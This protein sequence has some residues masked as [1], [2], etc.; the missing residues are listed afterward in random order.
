MEAENVHLDTTIMVDYLLKGKSKRAAVSG[1]LGQ[2][3]NSTTSRY[4]KA[5]FKKGPLQYLVYLHN[6]FC[7]AE[8]I[9]QIFAAISKLPPPQDRR[10]RSI[11]EQF[12]HFF[13]HA[14]KKLDQASGIPSPISHDQYLL[15][16]G[17][18]YFANLIESS[19]YEFDA[20]AKNIIDPQSC[21]PDM[22][23]PR[24]KGLLFSNEPRTCDKST[25]IC[26]CR[27]FYTEHAEE[28]QRV[29]E[30]LSKTAHP[31]E[32]TRRRIRAIREILRKPARLKEEDC[33]R[34]GDATVAIEAPPRSAIFNNNVKHF[35]PICSALAKEILT[36]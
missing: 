29:Y 32:E 31:D 22:V 21:F 19:W 28:L 33:W 7:Q 23:A 34:C 26:G 6:K 17:R 35:E 5:E 4:V 8:S 20:V 9:T 3:K 10:L 18:S 13:S 2:F 30:A 25:A 15:E 12:E 36:Y 11:L 27:R 24:R 1:K 14:L 16:T